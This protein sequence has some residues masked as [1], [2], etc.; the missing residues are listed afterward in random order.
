MNDTENIP[1]KR[2]KTAATT[3]TEPEINSKRL[4]RSFYQVNAT[5]LAQE[6]LGQLLVRELEDGSILKGKIVETEAY[7]GSED[8]ACHA[9]QGRR[10]PAKEPMY[11]QP[12]SK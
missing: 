2:L 8:K 6:L 12:G 10:T 7:L 9:Y 11:M 3:S 4:L 5:E 1:H